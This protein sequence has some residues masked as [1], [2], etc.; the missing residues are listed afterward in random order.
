[1]P[2]AGTQRPGHK[3]LGQT[4]PHP[5]CVEAA[6][7]DIVL[8]DTEQQVRLAERAVRELIDGRPVHVHELVVSLRDFIRSA[9]DLAPIPADLAIPMQGPARS[10]GPRGGGKSERGGSG[11][12]RAGMGGGM[13]MGIGMASAVGPDEPSSTGHSG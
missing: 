5:R 7:S 13:G 11:G 4:T 8:L 1:V 2:R 9:L 6:L 12:G 3:W 10:S